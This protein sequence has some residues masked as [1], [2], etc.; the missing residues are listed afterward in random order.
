MKIRP[1]RGLPTPHKWALSTLL[2]VAMSSFAT[3]G[4]AAVVFQTDFNGVD[5]GTGGPTDFITIGGTGGPQDSVGIGQ[6]VTVATTSPLAAGSGGYLHVAVNNSSAAAGTKYFSDAPT[7]AV[8]NSLNAL[9]QGTISN[10]ANTFANLSGGY[11][12]FVRLNSFS[13]TNPGEW[14]QGITAFPGANEL[15]FV[16]TG[17]GGGE[18]KVALLTA[19]GEGRLSNFT[20]TGGLGSGGFNGD[21]S[22]VNLHSTGTSLLNTPGQTVHFGFTYNTDTNGLVTLKLFGTTGTGAIDT[23]SPDFLLVAATFNVSAAGFSP[24]PVNTFWNPA[25]GGYIGNPTTLDADFDRISLYNSDPGTFAALAVPEPS[26]FALLLGATSL[27]L[28]TSA[29][30]RISIRTSAGRRDE[31]QRISQRWC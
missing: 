7:D 5:G 28:V 30:R 1:L 15:G 8:A 21:N 10:G 24:A 9:Y 12:V 25:T 4:F 18:L 16:L 17:E 27:V 31:R 26:S 20:Q 11:D 13:G 22:E 2:I 19:G 29:T 6:T 14:F 23:S 3:N